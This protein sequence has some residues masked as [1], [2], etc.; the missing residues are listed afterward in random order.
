M[1][2]LKLFENHN[3]YTEIDFDE[4]D[5]LRGIDDGVNLEKPITDREFE[6]IRS[7]VPKLKC[8]KKE[9]GIDRKKRGIYHQIEITTRKETF[10]I[11]KLD[12]D[13]W[14]VTSFPIEKGHVLGQ[15]RIFRYELGLFYKCDQM[16]G[17]KK[18]FQ[19]LGLI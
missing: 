12:D 9:L 19:D 6:M 14:V 16:D 11:V 3:Y 2:H 7:W 13:W 15:L 10:Y 17:L 18:L 8:L 4:Y 5:A 1:K